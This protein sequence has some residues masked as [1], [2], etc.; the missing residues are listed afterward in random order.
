[1]NKYFSL[2]LIKQIFR[3]GVV[4]LIAAAVHFGI[5]IMLVQNFR[6]TPLIANLFGFMGGV[7][8][9]Y[10]GHRFWT[11]SHTAAAHVSAFLK[12]VLLQGIMLIANEILFYV[13][14]LLGLPYPI[15]LLFVL[16]ILPFFT[17]VCSKRLIFY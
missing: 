9:S 7:F 5:V 14:M 6:Y 3:F 12:L 4:G 17:F 11:F 13:F 2:F 10:S 15:A 1:M 8:F 16:S